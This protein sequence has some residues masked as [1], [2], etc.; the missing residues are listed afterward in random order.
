MNNNRHD[1]RDQDSGRY[2]EADNPKGIT[3]RG[4][5]SG[6]STKENLERWSAVSRKNSYHSLNK[7]D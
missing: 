1:T 4:E 6:L 2:C 7:D 3:P 5:L